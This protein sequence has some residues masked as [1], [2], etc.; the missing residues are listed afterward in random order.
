MV[1]NDDL[2]NCYSEIL[3]VVENVIFSKKKIT[4]D[5]ELIERHVEKLIS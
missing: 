4:F 3:N 1:I 2:N 5:K